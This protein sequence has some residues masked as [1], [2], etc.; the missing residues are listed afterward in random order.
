MPYLRK[1][2]TSTCLRKTRIRARVLQIV[3][4]VVEER[5]RPFIPTWVP[6]NL[7]SLLSKMWAH[8][9]Y[10]RPSIQEVLAALEVR[11]CPIARGKR[12][13]SRSA[14]PED[15]PGILHYYSGRALTVTPPG[16]R[17]KVCD[18]KGPV[19]VRASRKS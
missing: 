14:N 9:P 2:Y 18:S 3:Q 19:T 10:E 12:A 11:P 8:S 13:Y 17:A 4:V 7:S 15:A 1:T 16:R 6:Y 5:Q